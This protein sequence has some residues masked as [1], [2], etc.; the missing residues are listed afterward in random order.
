VRLSSG[1]TS[2]QHSK[3]QSSSIKQATKQQSKAAATAK[4]SELHKQQQWLG[5]ACLMCSSEVYSVEA[6]LNWA[7]TS[8]IF[9]K[10]SE[11]HKI[12]SNLKFENP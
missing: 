6:T 10:I 2:E 4:Q 12:L 5:S 8:L 3:Q 7:A 11:V 9:P 1:T